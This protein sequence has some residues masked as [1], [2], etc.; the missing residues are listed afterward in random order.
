MCLFS[1][2]ME[3]VQEKALLWKILSYVAEMKA[4]LTAQQEKNR[5]EIEADIVIFVDF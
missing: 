2:L 1:G 3:S 4:I 5:I